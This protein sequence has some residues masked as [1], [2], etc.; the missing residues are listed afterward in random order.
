MKGQKVTLVCRASY[1]HKSSQMTQN[2]VLTVTDKNNP[3]TN[4]SRKNEV[5]N[6]GEGRD[7]I[8]DSEVQTSLL[9]VSNWSIKM[10]GSHI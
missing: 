9:G 1:N 2:I 4:A 7:Y 10:H 6:L 5:N 8:Y 3:Q